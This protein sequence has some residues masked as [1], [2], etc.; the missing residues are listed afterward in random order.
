M[1]G[2]TILNSF[3]IVKRELDSLDGLI[4]QENERKLQLQSR[5]ADCRE[6]EAD[7]RLELSSR[8]K[9]IFNLESSIQVCKALSKTYEAAEERE[10][11]VHRERKVK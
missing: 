2:L 9:E 5:A 11:A 10:K 8:T 6:D 4:L 1:T 3:L 7:I